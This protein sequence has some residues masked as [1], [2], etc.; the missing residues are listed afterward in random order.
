MERASDMVLFHERSVNFFFCPPTVVQVRFA[1]H[2]VAGRMPGQL[3]VLL[4]ESG[5]PYDVVEEM[6]EINDDFPETDVA[7]VIGANDTVNS[8]AY[9][10]PNSEIAGMPVLEVW[11]AKSCVVMKRT[12][13]AGYAGVDN[14]VFFKVNSYYENTVYHHH[15]RRCHRHGKVATKSSK[16]ERARRDQ[17]R[18]LAV[19]KARSRHGGVCVMTRSR[20]TESVLAC[21][22]RLLPPPRLFEVSR[23]DFWV[24]LVK[25][26]TTCVVTAAPPRFV[27][28]SLRRSPRPTCSLATP[29]TSARRCAPRSPRSTAPT[30][31]CDAPSPPSLPTPPLFAVGSSALVL[32]K[33]ELLQ[34]ACRAVERL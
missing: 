32:R 8:A 9:E 11:K 20:I 22:L 19:A 6:D 1:I 26:L 15:H 25:R 4:A 34:I 2:P 5:V 3:N 7:V 33:G 17:A 10:D 14:P 29:R 30:R 21:F 24:A 18:S 16:R 27:S 28:S 23:K 13:G 12:M 31:S